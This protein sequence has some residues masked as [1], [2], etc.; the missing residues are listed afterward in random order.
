[1]KCGDTKVEIYTQGI[2]NINQDKPD[3]MDLMAA[4]DLVCTN[5]ITACSF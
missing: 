3:L 5:E 4:H 2:T 1:M